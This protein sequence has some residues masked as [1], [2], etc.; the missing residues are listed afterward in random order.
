M[1]GVE[2]MLEEIGIA[3]DQTP[4]DPAVYAMPDGGEIGNVNIANHDDLITPF[5]INMDENIGNAI[6]RATGGVRDRFDF[7]LKDG[8]ILDPGKTLREAGINFNDVIRLVERDSGVGSMVDSNSEGSDVT[9]Q[10]LAEIESIKDEEMSEILDEEMYD[11]GKITITGVD[12]SESEYLVNKN[13]SIDNI[14]TRYTQ[15]RDNDEYDLY[16]GSRAL[17][18]NISL[19]DAGV[20]FRSNL[21]LAEREINVFVRNPE[22]GSM[23]VQARRSNSVLWL[24]ER[25]RDR[26]QVPTHQQRLQFQSKPLEDTH[27]LKSYGIKDCSHIESTYRLR[28][29][30]N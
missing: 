4:I 3:S 25:Y 8:T 6:T 9:L 5:N 17:P 14:I 20:R 2:Q 18:R 13:D 26:Y 11:N 22:G 12:G 24:K 28:G 10:D 23:T 16:D 21:R 7:V 29:G 1:E 19:R 15:T 27:T 30:A